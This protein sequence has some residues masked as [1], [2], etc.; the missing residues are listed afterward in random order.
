MNNSPRYRKL[1]RTV[2]S[3]IIGSKLTPSELHSLAEELLRGR[4]PEEL[5]YMLD[6]V[7]KHL[8]AERDDRA[9]EDSV[10]V[11]ERLVK[12]RKVSRSALSNIVQSLGGQPAPP[13]S[14]VRA[15]LRDFIS[16]ASPAR[17]RKL[18]EILKSTSEGDAFL[19]GISGTRK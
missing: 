7:T 5:A 18:L 6:Q 10:I 13:K 19:A 14:S 12:Q 17:T 4:F 3:G 11:A 9:N 16:E 15:L 8:I 2:Y 1:L